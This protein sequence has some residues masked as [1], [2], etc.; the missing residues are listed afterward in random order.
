MTL[1]LNAAK[2]R[3]QFSWGEVSGPTSYSA[4][5][6]VI[7]LRDSLSEVLMFDLVLQTLGA[8]LV[9]H[10]L[11]VALNSPTAGQVTVKVMRRRYDK[12]S[13]FGNVAGQPGGVTIQTSAQSLAAEAS[14]THSVVH[15]HAAV[16]SGVASEAMAGPA[17]SGGGGAVRVD[18]HT[19][20]LDLSSIG[21][22]SAS[23]SSHTHTWSNIYQH[24][25]AITQTVTDMATVEV[26]A[27]VNLSTSSWR[28]LAMGVAA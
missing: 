5:G 12:L 11:V 1:T 9:P 26:A 27:A 22:T 10:D 16:T 28:Y 18:A 7:D 14:H 25:H 2:D 3:E 4:G 8:S 21:V 17:I 15:D 6:F 13:S 19:H 24:Q 23:G 20:S